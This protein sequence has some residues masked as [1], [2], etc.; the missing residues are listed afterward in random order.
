MMQDIALALARYHAHSARCA[1]LEARALTIIENSRRCRGAVPPGASHPPRRDG[2]YAYAS[3]SLSVSPMRP[4]AG[5][6]SPSP[7]FLI[8]ARP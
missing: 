2:E 6:G 3:S 8:E 5:G 4:T 1:A 7:A